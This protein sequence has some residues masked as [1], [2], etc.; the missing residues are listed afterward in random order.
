[1]HQTPLV[2][3]FSPLIASVFAIPKRWFAV[4]PQP[5]TSPPEAKDS[6][7]KEARRVTR[8]ALEREVLGD[9]DHNQTIVPPEGGL[10]GNG[11]CCTHRV[12]YTECDVGR[13]PI[14]LAQQ[15]ES[16]IWRK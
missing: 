4:K 14:Y 15:Y 9:D 6:N 8:T 3:T 1:M 5:D 10:S 2:A 13:P 7:R 12:E 11:Q 16:G